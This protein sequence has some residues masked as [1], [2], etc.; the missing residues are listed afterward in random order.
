[1]D[2]LRIGWRTSRRAK[3]FGIP[4]TIVILSLSKNLFVWVCRDV[5][6]EGLIEDKSYVST[7]GDKK[8]VI[9][10][11]PKREWQSV[12]CPP[13]LFCPLRFFIPA[14]R[15]CSL[16]VVYASSTSAPL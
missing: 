13:T 11:P 4:Q 10:I 15:V 6:P 12:F 16:N 2:I 5:N 8:H 1:M 3:A 9:A 14:N 7:Y